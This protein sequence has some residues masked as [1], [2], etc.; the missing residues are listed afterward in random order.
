MNNVMLYRGGRS[1]YD[2]M[3]GFFDKLSSN[4]SWSPSVDVREEDGQYI[5]EAE[6]PGM[7]E[8]DIDVNVND[9]LLTITAKKAEV[10]EKKA[11]SD[12]GYKFLLRERRNRQF[13]RSFRL[14][15]S[16]DQGKIHAD[17]QNGLLTLEIS[18]AQE[19]RPRTIKIN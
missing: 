1:L 9:G 11:D 2:E 19:A 18:K 13:S 17:Y 7:S 12:K 16:A 10:Q 15:G 4:E 3:E 6:L 5:L 14:P 8:K